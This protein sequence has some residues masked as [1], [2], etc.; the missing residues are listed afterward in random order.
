MGASTESDLIRIKQEKIPIVRCP[1]ANAFFHL[2][3]DLL[4][5]QKIGV[6]LMLGTDNAMISTPNILEEIRFLKKT[7]S[8]YSD[9]QLLKMITYTPRKVLNL[10]DCIQGLYPSCTFVV[11]ERKSLLPLYISKIK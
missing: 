2:P 3:V 10:D 1:R 4:L 7:D 5:M 9:E 8:H 11:L 6:D